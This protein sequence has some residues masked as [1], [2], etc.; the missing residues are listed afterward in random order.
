M[1]N[2]VILL[3]VQTSLILFLIRMVHFSKIIK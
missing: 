1:V 3:I 2:V